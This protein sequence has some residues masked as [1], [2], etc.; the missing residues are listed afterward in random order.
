MLNKKSKA[1]LII[2]KLCLNMKGG[3]FHSIGASRAYYAI[4]QETKYLLEKNCFDYTKFKLDNPGARRHSDYAHGSI[5]NALKYFLFNNGFN[6]QDD[7]IFINEMSTAFKKLYRWRI[8]ADYKDGI[9]S[10]KNLGEAIERAE[11]FIIKLKK[12][13][14]RG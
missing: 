5:R 4:F 3:V 13:D 9:I 6:E 2:A 10:K 7:L 1:N 14:R 8:Q 12:Y 11:M